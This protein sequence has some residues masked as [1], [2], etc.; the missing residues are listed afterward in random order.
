MSSGLV[1]L[2][3]GLALIAFSRSMVELLVANGVLTVGMGFNSPSLTS[4]ISQRSDPEDQGGIL[5]VSQ[6]LASLARIVGPAWGGFLFDRWGM[7]SPYLSSAALILVACGIS[8][9]ALR[10]ARAE[11]TMIEL[12]GVTKQFDGK[13]RVTALADVNLSIARGELVSI[14]GPSG[15]G[16]STLLNLIGGLDRPTAGEIAIDGQALGGLA[17]DELTRVRRDKIGFIFQFFNLL[18]SLSCLENVALPLHLR[19]WPRKKARRAGAGAARAGAAR[20]RA[21]ITRPTNCR[22]A[23]ASGRRSRARCRSTRR[24]CWPTSRPATSTRTPARRSS[25]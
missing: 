1:M 17:D 14:V 24:S 25:A 23:S 19:G 9:V 4:L 18:P 20:A 21:S 13:R 7:T 22:A 15:S 10:P 16:K 11:G 5:G 6:S 2:A 8:I 3:L 12:D